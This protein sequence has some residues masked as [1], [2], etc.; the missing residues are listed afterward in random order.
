M[1]ETA[2]HLLRKARKELE[3]LGIETAALD[4]RLL[5]QAAAHIT[6]EELVA[7]PD[8]AIADAAVFEGLIARRKKF[9]PVSRIL[10]EREFYGRRFKV[11]TDV[12][13]PR[14]DS[15][16]LID[17][18][19]KLVD[20][21]G[22]PRIL[23]LGTGSGIL[24]ITL[25]AEIP[26]ATGLATDISVEALITV[27]DNGVNLGVAHRLDSQCADWFEGVAGRFDL[28]VSN[29]PYIP[30]GD[31][32]GLAPDVR[33]YDPHGAL[34]GGED[35]LD[36]YRRLASRAGAH[37]T[38]TGKILVEVG[39]GQAE[40]VKGIFLTSGFKTLNQFPDLGGHI[41]VLVFLA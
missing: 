15:E 6:H 12:L 33:D 40:A 32:E 30:D 10:G 4:A 18:A 16:T 31:I 20:P 23:D 38:A 28:I 13:D 34:A 8:E 5:L 21:Q 9:E 25:L 36:A 26:R 35:G 17:A 11:T 39:A 29:P 7:N 19:L 3:A 22:A 27:M 37:L 14:A 2:S 41:R 24:A 1:P